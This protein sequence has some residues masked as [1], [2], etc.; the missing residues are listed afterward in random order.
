MSISDYD[1]ITLVP[2][3]E[4]LKTQLYKH[5]LA[6]INMMEVLERRK[7]INFSNGEKCK[8]M[9]GI[10]ADP[11]GYGKTLSIVGLIVR[12]K[13]EWDLSTPYNKEHIDI[14]ANGLVIRTMIEKYEKIKPT[15]ILVSPS[16]V[17]QWKNEFSKSYLNV[18]TITKNKEIND[19]E[20]LNDYDVILV[21]STMYNHLLYNFPNYAWKRFIYDEP[22]HVKI[23]TMKNITAG[24]YWFVTATPSSI[25]SLH[26]RLRN[27]FMARLVEDMPSIINYI[28][29]KNDD[30][31]V[32]LSFSMPSVNRYYYECYQPILKT[33][34]GLVS[35]KIHYMIS[36]G[37]IEEVITTLGGIKTN[38]IIELVK[39]KY[40]DD[41]ETAKKD[42]RVY[43]EIINNEIKL[44][45]AVKEK[46]NIE[47]KLEELESR[48]QLMLKQNCSIC[49]GELNDTILEPNCQNLFCGKCLLSWLKDKNTCP[50][51][52]HHLKI[53][54]L[55]YLSEKEGNNDNCSNFDTKPLSTKIEKIIDIINNNEKGKYIIFSEFD[56][57]FSPICRVLKQ[58][59]ITFSEIK[60][61]NTTRKKNIEKFKYGDTQVI[62]LNSNYNGSGIN[63]QEATDII[64][65]HEMSPDIETQI[66]GRA[67]RIG[68]TTSLNIHYLT[69]SI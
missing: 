6:I 45:K 46:E 7:E 55:V 61:S 9:L 57:T 11:T 54:Q 44:E 19:L 30:E 5:Q 25:H 50:L 20:N 13:M 47:R 51:C 68:R 8:T 4:N 3:P 59:N 48:F 12:D 34:H 18:K 14:K 23:K 40:I 69:D 41:L 62:F 56:N 43:T 53:S 42:I 63:L 16:I 29:I 28:T 66:I 26:L 52:R 10:N 58:S 35:P 1:N 64:L 37:N 60:G 33:L 17:F 15:L 2:Q 39:Q 32:K 31:F 67:N 21:I 24:F 27:N 49:M 36:A 38:S 65:Y 22:A